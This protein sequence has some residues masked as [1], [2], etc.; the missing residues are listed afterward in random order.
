MYKYHLFWK[1]S[2]LSEL[3][4]I[5]VAFVKQ[6][7]GFLVLSVLNVAWLINVFVQ[8]FGWDVVITFFISILIDKLNK[9][10]EKEIQE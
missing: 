8:A 2:I 4:V 7:L 1:K 10:E 9:K 3:Y 6:K 5:V